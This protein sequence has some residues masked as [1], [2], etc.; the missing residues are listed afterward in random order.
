MDY[1]N[2]FYV[3]LNNIN[4]KNFMETK[5][6]EKLNKAINFIKGEKETALINAYTKEEYDNVSKNYDKILSELMEK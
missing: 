5:L 4:N 1:Q 2:M 3:D 6:E